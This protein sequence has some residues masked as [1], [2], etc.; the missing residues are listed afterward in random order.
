MHAHGAMG[1]RAAVARQFKLCRRELRNEL[2]IS[3][4]PQTEQLYESLVRV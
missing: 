1:N 2:D 3:P 4:S